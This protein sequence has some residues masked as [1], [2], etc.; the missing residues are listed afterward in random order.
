MRYCNDVQW[1]FA[2][3]LPQSNSFIYADSTGNITF[4]DSIESNYSFLARNLDSLK[5]GVS[6]ALYN[7]QPWRDDTTASILEPFLNSSV[8]ITQRSLGKGIIA[9]D[10]TGTGFHIIHSMPGFPAPILNTTVNGVVYNVKFPSVFP[11]SWFPVD[12]I[13]GYSRPSTL[14][15]FGHV[16]FCQSFIDPQ[17]LF[18]VLQYSQPYIYR[19][20]DQTRFKSLLN[21]PQSSTTPITKSADI[22]AATT[23]FTSTE[24]SVWQLNNIIPTANKKINTMVGTNVITETHLPYDFYSQFSNKLTR[25]RSSNEAGHIGYSKSNAIVNNRVCIGDIFNQEVGYIRSETMV[26]VKNSKLRDFLYLSAYKQR[27]LN[28]I[29]SVIGVQ[30]LFSGPIQ[31]INQQNN[32]FQST[33]SLLPY[34][35]SISD[36][37]LRFT[38]FEI[39][40]T[41][42]ELV[43]PTSKLQLIN[44]DKD[45]MVTFNK[46]YQP[47]SFRLKLSSTTDHVQLVLNGTTTVY[48]LA[49]KVY[50][51]S[52]ILDQPSDTDAKLVFIYK[53]IQSIHKITTP[54]LVNAG[55]P[56]SISVVIQY[57]NQTNTVQLG[58]S[59]LIDINLNNICIESVF[60]SYS[61]FLITTLNSGL[62]N[63]TSLQSNFQG[64][65][66]GENV[67][68]QV[69]V[70]GLLN[71]LTI[72]YRQQIFKSLPDSLLQSI[73]QCNSLDSTNIEYYNNYQYLKTDNGYLSDGWVTSFFNDIFDNN[74]DSR[75]QIK[76]INDN[77]QLPA[78]N[79]FQT[80]SQFIFD[81]NKNT[82]IFDFINLLNINSNASTSI[83]NIMKY[84]NIFQC[85]YCSA[86]P[87]QITVRVCQSDINLVGMNNLE[88]YTLEW[89]SNDSVIDYPI[90]WRSNRG[91]STFYSDPN[92]YSKLQQLQNNKYIDQDR[93][94]DCNLFPKQNSP[95]SPQ[96]F[97]EITQL[98]IDLMES[99]P[100]VDTQNEYLYPL[101]YY[102][103]PPSDQVSPSLVIVT[104]DDSLCAF[105]FVPPSQLETGEVYSICPTQ[106][107]ISDITGLSG[108]TSQNSQITIIGQQLK[109]AIVQFGPN[110]QCILNQPTYFN[111]ITCTA[112]K[113]VGIMDLVLSNPS[114]IDQQS[115]LPITS[116]LDYK[117]VFDAPIITS[118]HDLNRKLA[119]YESQSLMTIIGKNFIGDTP[120]IT[121]V[122]L[123]INNGELVVKP[124]Q[125]FTQ[126]GEDYIVFRPTIGCGSANVLEVVVG[127]QGQINKH[128]TNITFLPPTITQINVNTSPANGGGTITISGTNFGTINN[129]ITAA[130]ISNDIQFDGA[131]WLSDTQISVKIP[132]GYGKDQ[133]ITVQIC[134][135][136]SDNN[137]NVK[138][139]YDPPTLYEILYEPF[140]TNVLYTQF[141]LTGK[142]LATQE[143]IP[144]VYIFGDVNSTIECYSYANEH[145]KGK[146]YYDDNGDPIPVPTQQPL[147]GPY[148]PFID[149]NPSY[150][151]SE[152]FDCFGCFISFG[153]G[154][155]IGLLVAVGNQNVSTS[156]LNATL[157]HTVLKYIAPSINSTINNTSPTNGNVLLTIKGLNFV[158]NEN[159]QY[160]DPEEQHYLDGGLSISN[161]TIGEL[162]SNCTDIYWLNSTDI[163]CKVGYGIGRHNI[164]VFVGGQ[165]LSNIGEHLFTYHPPTM[166]SF[167]PSTTFNTVGGTIITIKGI[168][169]V[170][171]EL[172]QPNSQSIDGGVQYSNVS[173]IRNFSSSD[174]TMNQTRNS[175]CQSIEWINSTTITCISPFGIGKNYNISIFVGAQQLTNFGEFKF[176][177]TPPISSSLVSSI[178]NSTRGGVNITI[179][180]E[181][182]VPNEKVTDGSSID[183]GQKVSNVSIGEFP[184]TNIEWTNSSTIICTL[185]P[186]V[187][188]NLNLG[189]IVGE[190]QLSNYGQIKFSYDP[191][192]LVEKRFL[193]PIGYTGEIQLTGTNFVPESLASQFNSQQPQNNPNTTTISI[194]SILC[195]SVQW[196]NDTTANCSVPLGTGKNKFINVT[197]GE[198]SIPTNDYFSFLPPNITS[199]TPTRGRNGEETTITI[200]GENFG[201]PPNE[202][203]KDLPQ[204][205]VLANQTESY[206]K[207]VTLVSTNKIICI[208]KPNTIGTYTI[209]V[210][211]D[212]QESNSSN[213]YTYGPPKINS[214]TPKGGNVNGGYAITIAGENLMEEDKNPP[215]VV[216][217][218]VNIAVNQSS[219]T[220]IIFQATKGGGRDI[221][222][223]V[224]LNG[225]NSNTDT[226]FCYDPPSIFSID[227]PSLKYED[228]QSQTIQLNGQDLGLNGMQLDE[229]VTIGSGTCI[230]SLID[231]SSLVSCD[232][233][234]GLVGPQ[235]VTLKFKGQSATNTII[236]TKQQDQPTFPGTPIVSGPPVFIPPPIF[237]PIVLHPIPPTG[238]VVVVPNISTPHHII[239]QYT[240]DVN[241]IYNVGPNFGYHRLTTTRIQFNATIT[242]KKESNHNHEVTVANPRNI[243]TYKTTM[244]LTPTSLDITTSYISL[245]AD[246]IYRGVLYPS[247]L[248]QGNSFTNSLPLPNSISGTVF[249]DHTFDL[250][251]NA[252]STDKPA[253]VRISITDSVVNQQYTITTP[254]N[255]EYSFK[256]AP[257]NYKISFPDLN[258][259]TQNLVA[260]ESG[261][262]PKLVMATIGQIF[263]NNTAANEIYN[264]P[265]DPRVTD[266]RSY[267]LSGQSRL[268]LQYGRT[269][270]SPVQFCYSPGG[271]TYPI[272]FTNNNAGSL[273]EATS[274]TQTIVDLLFSNSL[275]VSIYTDNQ[276]TGVPTTVIP[277]GVTFTVYSTNLA[278]QFGPFTPAAN[279][280]SS[281]VVVP[282]GTNTIT[283]VSGTF[284]S[285]LNN[286]QFTMNAGT[287]T[288]IKFGMIQ[289]S[290]Y[291]NKFVKFFDQP[292][293]TGATL[294]LPGGLYHKPLLDTFAWTSKIKSFQVPTP[295]YVYLYSQDNSN[296]RIPLATTGNVVVTAPV[297]ARIEISYGDMD[298]NIGPDGS[299]F[300]LPYPSS[301]M[302]DLVLKYP[303]TPTK[304]VELNCNSQTSQCFMPSGFG[305]G[306]LSFYYKGQLL[307]QKY[308]VTFLKLYNIPTP[309]SF[310]YYLNRL[311][312]SR[313]ILNQ[314]SKLSLTVGNYKSELIL[315][316]YGLTLQVTIG[317]AAPTVLIYI[318]NIDLG[319]GAQPYQLVFNADTTLCIKGFLFC[320]GPLTRVGLQAQ[321]F[322]LVQNG[323][324]MQNSKGE[325]IWSRLVPLPRAADKI[326]NPIHPLSRS[327]P[328][329]DALG[330]YGPTSLQQGTYLTNGVEY[331]SIEPSG[332]ISISIMQLPAS[333]VPSIL[334]ISSLP[335]S[336]TVQP[337]KLTMRTDSN[338]CI[339]D[340]NGANA[341]CSSTQQL[342]GR[343]FSLVPS[344]QL[345]QDWG[346]HIFTLDG[347]MVFGNFKQTLSKDTI[348]TIKPIFGTYLAPS[349]YFFQYKSYGLQQGEFLSN[350][351]SYLQLTSQGI[352]NL[353]SVNPKL[354]STQVYWSSNNQPSF[355]GPY[356]L[357]MIEGTLTVC[358]PNSATQR[359]AIITPIQNMAASSYL[360]FIIPG[361]DNPLD[362]AF[363]FQRTA[364]HKVIGGQLGAPYEINNFIPRQPVT[365]A[366]TNYYIQ[367]A[368][369][370]TQTQIILENVKSIIGGGK[371]LID[372]VQFPAAPNKKLIL[373]LGFPELVTITNNRI[374]NCSYFYPDKLI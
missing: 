182:F 45:G 317:T 343:F 61:Y 102:Y 22:N 41:N 50:N 233:P 69:F 252:T 208:I 56:T 359:H 369:K 156:T 129:N 239:V 332:Q 172:L 349:D 35:Q 93:F 30:T 290:L 52:L 185:P 262:V 254:A 193:V 223:Y 219:F 213:W 373:I 337:F 75:D 198:Q 162:G 216:M 342:G 232:A 351:R 243:K 71:S 1:V 200:N 27:D 163:I 43:D 207:N 118:H 168:N 299:L 306:E 171:N 330:V 280:G 104:L 335:I 62:K 374:T 49:L 195:K 166:E 114:P 224:S 266:C 135:Q 248:F 125:L 241:L 309:N 212:G 84:D 76:I 77:Y 214:I 26:C 57:N 122:D 340:G 87:T 371:L 278:K 112:P 329:L 292:N 23:I 236:Y 221:P 161:V 15:D 179:S 365:A 127:G 160:L 113:G 46:N 255:G 286:Y 13:M 12:D 361:S 176:S 142:N 364:D 318:S 244:S 350:G 346:Y 261:V 314:G 334:T 140:P 300:T 180:G 153:I 222:I 10:N 159:L 18:D 251:Y 151:D 289:N 167:N 372:I 205:I 128:S 37:L 362:W 123:V 331:L 206:I 257:G 238:P 90:M 281:T 326:I 131:V 146:Q 40:T 217:N 226:E 9:V 307:T 78:N 201:I 293:F 8:Q 347:R 155:D 328:C 133:P 145:F 227:P 188:K 92:L 53:T 230:N 95:I 174:G 130:F 338:L 279:T 149:M 126:N 240:N 111:N 97:I 288:Q 32:L 60:K 51:D 144:D 100:V 218:N 366:I 2:R 247:V 117:F 81:S 274:V 268:N 110:A 259:N 235:T 356:T 139:S 38:N 94:V 192:T 287:S 269:N 34:Y 183:G 175:L 285:I 360:Y 105:D 82:I 323:A 348:Q 225:N 211:L 91:L 164:S 370:S 21:P 88:S 148:D 86:T 152:E 36:T 58:Q 169:F 367:G 190:Q 246:V 231:D 106:P 67:G 115:L 220:Q 283:L 136:F 137:T 327:I 44:S 143:Y 65:S 54:I 204:P 85:T 70:R 308:G 311:D 134:D 303:V 189:V 258:P 253:S 284:T 99:A 181:Q 304:T 96:S 273:C 194:G 237:P 270:I 315:N 184:S 147:D 138:F 47:N 121:L 73:D 310:N 363:I 4:I 301:Y 42:T 6:Y 186:G 203:G 89:A 3:K 265:L 16:F 276:I 25:W 116:N 33:P 196:I 282:A 264:L 325:V 17:A 294:N 103:Y 357:Q 267:V 150:R 234:T 272:T 295:Y 98:L 324:I 132:V 109:N 107:V 187:G 11:T 59:P 119:S 298:L 353:Y 199:I 108:P 271:C 209:V 64:I 333:T 120:N 336:S 249:I 358:G 29:E 68:P 5:L 275:T 158:P 345:S 250:K 66:Q 229:D 242:I 72:F 165:Q 101:R 228:T 210:R 83:S 305:G 215:I 173:I 19:S 24:Q 355:T 245:V 80:I 28:G 74:V 312:P 124:T 319:T 263:I 313:I 316:T 297:V 178:S 296:S 260:N 277:T 368:N 154:S 321:Y 344:D 352:V 48:S 354:A 339:Q 177:F 322:Q 202:G 302:K 14:T 291:S 320:L 197:I 31:F 157:P 79:L 341:W 63:I 55:Y 20:N 170:P 39:Q 141:Y 191:P 256:M 7:D